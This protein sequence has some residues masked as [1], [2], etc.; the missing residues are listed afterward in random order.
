M[1][2]LCQEMLHIWES[3]A[4]HIESTEVG[5]FYTDGLKWNQEL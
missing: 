5:L 3:T 1:Q 2:T 4:F